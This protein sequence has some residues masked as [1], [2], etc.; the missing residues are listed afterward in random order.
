MNKPIKVIYLGS[1]KEAIK[2]LEYL[3]KHASNVN[4]VGVVSQPAKL[5]GRGKK[6]KLVDPPVAEFAKE[7]N[8]M[9]LQ[10]ISARNEDFLSSLQELAPDIMITCAYGQIL[11]SNFLSI[12]SRA[13]INIHPSLLPKYRGATPV[14]AALRD[15]LT[16]TG[17]SILFTVKKLDAGAII[18]QKVYTIERDETSDQL[19]NRLFTE[20][21]PLLV[22]AIDKLQ[23]PS[24]SGEA[25]EEEEVTFCQ[26]IS[27]EDGLIDWSSSASDI[28]N[29]Y[30]AFTPWPGIYSYLG[31]KRVILQDLAAIKED[32]DTKPSQQEQLGSFN[33]CKQLKMLVVKTNTGQIGV[34]SLKLE[35]SKS[36]DAASFWNGLKNKTSQR[37]TIHA[38]AASPS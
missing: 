25:Q 5:A 19:L 35:G 4:V 6:K 18:S 28:F 3:L 11:C 37:F 20:S 22:Q 7:N 24:F 26:K 29:Q 27:K 33:Y 13:T 31:P 10:P 17:I 14:Q 2:P 9:V 38:Q 30:R 12:P 16:S 34:G 23:D 15:G 1:P 8:L 21:G 36:V 32:L